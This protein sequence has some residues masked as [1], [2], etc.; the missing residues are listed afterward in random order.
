M[1]IAG[2]GA[3]LTGRAMTPILIGTLCVWPLT[4]PAEDGPSALQALDLGAAE[5]GP[6]CVFACEAT[7]AA[8]K[9]QCRNAKARADVEHFDEPDVSV[10]ACIKDCQADAAICEEDC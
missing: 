1:D 3:I 2:L 9:E 7:L 4:V 6:T 5:S 8:C 10:S